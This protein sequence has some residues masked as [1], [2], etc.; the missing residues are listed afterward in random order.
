MRDRRA[1]G[2]GA[3]FTFV[4]TGISKTRRH[5]FLQ[6]RQVRPDALFRRTTENN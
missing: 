2:R 5:E 1:A 3:L 6:E 4:P